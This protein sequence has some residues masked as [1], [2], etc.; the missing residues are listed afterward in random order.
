MLRGDGRWERIVSPHLF[1]MKRERERE[2]EKKAS[3]LNEHVK[4]DNNKKK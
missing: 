2:K 1:T 3:K 4:T